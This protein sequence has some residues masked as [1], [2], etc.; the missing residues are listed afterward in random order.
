MSFSSDAKAELIRLPLERDCCVL[1]ELSALT[2]TTG[3]LGF[4][5]GGR[6]SVSWQVENAALARRIF[7]MLKE[8]L[9]LSPSLHF[10]QH[11]RLG[12]RRTCVL[13]VEGDDA[14]KLLT[15]LRMM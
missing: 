3:S 14:P 8:R 5:G 6:F 15:A 11:A 1:A 12:G 9:G 2:Q 4:Q 7:R 10:V 13:T